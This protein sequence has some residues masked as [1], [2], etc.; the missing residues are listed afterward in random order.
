VPLCLLGRREQ[1]AAATATQWW[2]VLGMACRLKKA[3]REA[4]VEGAALAAMMVSGPLRPLWRPFGLR[5]TCVPPDFAT[6]Y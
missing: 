3:R 6:K 1:V 2:D 4:G 5:F